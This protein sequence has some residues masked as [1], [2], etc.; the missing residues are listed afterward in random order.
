M[1]RT[2][3]HV[4]R[5]EHSEGLH[6]NQDIECEYLTAEASRHAIVSANTFVAKNNTHTE[7][8]PY[9]CDKDCDENIASIMQ[10]IRT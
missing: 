2:Y 1:H 4:H 7:L 10:N 6:W 5:L 3:N 9:H 8:V